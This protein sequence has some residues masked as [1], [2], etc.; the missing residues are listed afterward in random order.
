MMGALCPPAR[1]VQRGAQRKPLLHQLLLFCAL[2]LAAACVLSTAQEDAH[3]HTNLNVDARGNVAGD[4][5]VE[6]A[7]DGQD[8]RRERGAVGAQRVDAAEPHTIGASDTI[9]VEP[10]QPVQAEDVSSAVVDGADV[11]TLQL[12]PKHYANPGSEI[13]CRHC[14]ATLSHSAAHAAHVRFT[15]KFVTGI[16]ED[17][18]SELGDGSTMHKVSIACAHLHASKLLAPSTR[19]FVQSCIRS[20]LL[21]ACSHCAVATYCARQGRCAIHHCTTRCSHIHRGKCCLLYHVSQ[22]DGTRLE[23]VCSVLSHL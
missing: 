20:Q 9:G 23:R 8:M 3:P 19:N 7:D 14:G 11:D 2:L 12:S 13:M 17:V 16:H 1:A 4:T 5:V 21:R 15:P 18:S 10:A 6:A 22:R